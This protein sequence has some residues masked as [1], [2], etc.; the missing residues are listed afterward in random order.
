[1]PTGLSHY[2]HHHLVA[3]LCE[4]LLLYSPAL[5]E[6]LSSEAALGSER[7]SCLPVSITTLLKG[8]NHTG[9]VAWVGMFKVVLGIWAIVCHLG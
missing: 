1:M 8:R 5:R 2:F 4:A 6:G 7:V 3:D 9:L